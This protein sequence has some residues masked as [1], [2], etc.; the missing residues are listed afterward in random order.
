[1]V[2]ATIQA[3]GVDSLLHVMDGSNLG[4]PLLLFHLIDVASRAHYLRL[5]A[6]ERSVC[7]C[8]HCSSKEDR[9]ALRPN[10]VQRLTL[11]R[12]SVES[13]PPRAR[14]LELVFTLPVPRT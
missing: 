2:R 9:V 4:T 14:I 10:T 7:M 3:A 12:V 5:R 6:R 8:R 11:T 1:M 13:N